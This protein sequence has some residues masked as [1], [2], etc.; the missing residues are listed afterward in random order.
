M[1]TSYQRNPYADGLRKHCRR[2]RRRHGN[3]YHF[4]VRTARIAPL[5][6]NFVRSA[7]PCVQMFV[8]RVR[9]ECGMHERTHALMYPV[10][11]A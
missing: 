1:R 7:C 4:D 8:L 3:Y 11:P 2:S 5:T 10:C 9:I 6:L